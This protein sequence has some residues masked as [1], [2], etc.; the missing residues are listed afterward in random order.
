MKVELVEQTNDDLSIV[1]TARVSMDKWSD[2]L[3]MTLNTKGVER[4]VSLINY[5][6]N[7]LHISTMFHQ[8]FTFKVTRWECDL[9]RIE[10]PEYLMGAVWKC[11]G[12]SATYYLRHSFWGWLNLIR[13]GYLISSPIENFLCDQFPIASVPAGLCRHLKVEPAEPV[14]LN[15]VRFIDVSLRITAPIFIMEHLYTHKMFAKNR[16]SRRYVDSEPTYFQ[17]NEV[18]ARPDGSI[19]QGSGG[20]HHGSNEMLNGYQMLTGFLT[21]VYERLIDEG[22]APEQARCILPVSMETSMINT[23]SLWHY[24]K[25]Y[26]LRSEGHAQKETQELA[27]LINEVLSDHPM[28]TQA[29][30]EVANERT[31]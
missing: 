27:R 2:K 7:H 11:D 22:V 10:N 1:N 24:A 12:N 3:D 15:D 26:N 16:V 6:V 18:R 17:F 30:V 4:D 14:E 23:G 29:L 25:L 31:N 28:W 5:L 13:Q 21:G 8:R 20:V 9:Y 19:K